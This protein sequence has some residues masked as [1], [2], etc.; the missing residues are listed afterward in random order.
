MKRKL[1][2]VF[3]LLLL[4]FS[5]FLIL[6]GYSDKTYLNTT[7]END[8]TAFL[9]SH[10]DYT[11]YTF[12]NKNISKTIK[13]EN[14]STWQN[15]MYDSKIQFYKKT[16]LGIA[17]FLPYYKPVSIN[18]VV[19]YRWEVI[20]KNTNENRI[21]KGNGKLKINGKTTYLGNISQKKVKK[22]ILEKV[23]KEAEK[24][25]NSE[26]DKRISKLF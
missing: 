14:D 1:V 2:F 20:I 16:D 9:N 26:I 24:N 3:F 22:I 6:G 21:L 18:S 5:L 8:T 17:R 10:P 13:S 7:Q 23:V 15:I 11:L 12:N 25:I 19:V 4:V